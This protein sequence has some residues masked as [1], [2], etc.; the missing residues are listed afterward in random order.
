MS[1]I[2]LKVLQELRI[3]FSTFY[4]N[5]AAEQF[6]NDMHRIEYDLPYFFGQNGLDFKYT[7]LLFSVSEL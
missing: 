3:K 4:V 7:N 5:F 6:S 1:R 2:T